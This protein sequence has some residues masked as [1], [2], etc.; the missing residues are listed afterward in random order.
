M[1]IIFNTYSKIILY[2]FGFDFYDHCIL[3]F[4]YNILTET[5]LLFV[6]VELVQS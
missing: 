2:S 3:N 6:F 5:P 1:I 4:F